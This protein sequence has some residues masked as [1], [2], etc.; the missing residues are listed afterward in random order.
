[1]EFT[2]LST[3]QASDCLVHDIVFD[4]YGKRFATCSTD[5]KIRVWDC[6]DDETAEG[7]SNWTPAE[8]S[9]VRR[10]QSHQILI[11]C[12][13]FHLVPQAHG[14]PIWRLS[15]AHPE[16]GLFIVISPSVDFQC[17]IT[18]N[19]IASCSE[20]RSV[21][22]WEEQLSVSRTVE[23]KERWIIKA[24]LSDGKKAINDVKFAPK[25]LGLKIA[26]AC[27]DGAV[28]VYDGEIFSLQSWLLQVWHLVATVSLTFKN[29]LVSYQHT[30]QV[31]ETV[32]ADGSM[33]L[34]A[35]H[36]EHGLTCLCWS[37][38]VFE[39]PRLAVGGFS[40]RA[41]VW[42]FDD[43]AGSTGKWREELELGSIVEQVSSTSASASSGV[44]HDIAW[45]PAMGRSYHLIAT[46]SR[47][48]SFKVLICLPSALYC[49][50]FCLFL[51][52]STDSYAPSPSGRHAA[53][54]RH[55]HRDLRYQLSHLARGLECNGHG[56]GHLCGGRD[57]LS[58]AQKFRGSVED[59]SEAA[60]E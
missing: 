3:G 13:L 12:R 57:A 58:L 24:R 36:S 4:F 53:I 42:I 43:T 10:S 45:A 54:R 11:C 7:R 27:A 59:G 52:W 60:R 41:V 49:N 40:R 22:I 38:C 28:R 17:G 1:M 26:A 5:G 2:Q 21:G 55:P 14:G 30:L 37:D 29:I 15:W 39:R 6:E 50:H 51:K 8:I 35:R 33:S 9:E 44:I 31:E 32:V 23:A 47:E 25:H 19:L 56:T 46:A 18:G 34:S 48:L 20:D 16:F